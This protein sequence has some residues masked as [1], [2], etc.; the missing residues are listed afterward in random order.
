MDGAQHQT[1]PPAEPDGPRVRS[2][3]V[4]TARP[5]AAKSGRSGIA[6]QAVAGPVAVA[7]PGPRGSRGEHTGGLAGDTIVDTGHHGGD[8]QAVYAYARE[9]LDAWQRQ[10][11]IDLPDG[12]FGENLTTVG[13]DV[14]GAR[15]GERW[16]VGDQ[17]VLQVTDP[18]VP[19]GTFAARMTELGRTGP[20]WLPQFTR[21]GTPGAYLSVVAPGEVSPGDRIVV[22]HRPAHEVTVGTVFRAL[23]DR[24][25]LLP[26]ILAAAADLPPATLTDVRRRL[27]RTAR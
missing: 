6:K 25:E 9:D 15:V 23:L 4:G 8:A 27:A 20:G 10:L 26:G 21:G 12:A 13:L 24:P 2:V 17:L 7:A 1:E 16:R 18:R 3:L 14:T 11:G 19:C 5:M 22:E